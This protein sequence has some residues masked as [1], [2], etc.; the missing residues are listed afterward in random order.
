MVA[1]VAEKIAQKGMSIEDMTTTLRIGHEG[2]REFVIDT[3]VSSPNLADVENLDTC[4]ADLST[5][6]TD[7]G[8]SHFDVRVHTN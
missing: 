7:L 5:I 4:I 2:K 3:R 6:E 8:L 1:L